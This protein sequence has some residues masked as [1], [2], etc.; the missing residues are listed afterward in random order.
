MNYQA[1]LTNKNQKIR[2][3]RIEIEREQKNALARLC[4]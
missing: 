4:I 2:K 3:Y 1:L